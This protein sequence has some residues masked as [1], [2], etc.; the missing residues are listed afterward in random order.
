MKKGNY[1]AEKAAKLWGYMAEEAAKLYCKEFGGVWHVVF[2]AATR[3]EMARQFEEN[4]REEVENESK[5]YI[6]R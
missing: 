6:E 3:R 5:A 1:D 2:S 4:Y